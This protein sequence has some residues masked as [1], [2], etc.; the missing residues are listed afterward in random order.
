MIGFLS[1]V[2]HK[3]CY[4]Q[5]MASDIDIDVGGLPGGICV[6]HELLPINSIVQSGI[7]VAKK[8]IAPYDAQ[9]LG[10]I[11]NRDVTILSLPQTTAIRRAFEN[12]LSLCRRFTEV[13]PHPMIVGLEDID[14]K[15]LER[16]ESLPCCQAAAEPITPQQDRLMLEIRD[17]YEAFIVEMEKVG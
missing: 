10:F 6:F 7:T 14:L 11:L 13:T 12:V 15:A 1:V 17:S 5:G 2:A 9:L 3:V 16:G 4:T 8:Q